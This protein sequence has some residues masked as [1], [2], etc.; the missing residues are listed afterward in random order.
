LKNE[1][2][3]LKNKITE[4]EKKI[5]IL[6]N[7]TEIG[8]NTNFEIIKKENTPFSEKKQNNLSIK[9][10]YLRLLKS[11]T[12]E[13]V[14]ISPYKSEK[15]NKKAVSKTRSES[16]RDK[17][18]ENSQNSCIFI[19][20]ICLDS[21]IKNNKSQKLISSS[22]N[23]AGKS[24]ARTRGNSIYTNT[25]KSERSLKN[26][27]TKIEKLINAELPSARR[28]ASAK[29]AK[30]ER[31][32][33]HSIDNTSSG[34]RQKLIESQKRSTQSLLKLTSKVFNSKGKYML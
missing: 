15:I 32:C 30:R 12:K 4:L 11:I 21:A 5:P 1:G 31:S 23:P 2:K 16:I 9:D 24:K 33:S 29:S 17:F 28:T 8:V 10:E 18:L 7:Y 27:T 25:L 22:G 20:E 13:K 19:I 34:S 3:I 14:L 26:V 6:K